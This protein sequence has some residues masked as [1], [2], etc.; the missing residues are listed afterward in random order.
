M[1]YQFDIFKKC[2]LDSFIHNLSIVINC[3]IIYLLYAFEF[4]VE[5]Q[6]LL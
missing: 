4:H 6:L 2:E 3:I 5:M 1:L